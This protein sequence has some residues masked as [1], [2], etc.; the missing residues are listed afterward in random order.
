MDKLAQKQRINFPIKSETIVN[1][2]RN[3]FAFDSNMSMKQH[4]S[5]NDFLN[6]NVTKESRVKYIHLRE[7]DQFMS[8]QGIGKVRRTLDEKTREVCEGHSYLQSILT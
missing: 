3:E 4:K 7:I 6:K 5:F 8:I 2:M 1:N